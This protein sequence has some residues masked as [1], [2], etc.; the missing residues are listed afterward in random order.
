[1]TRL[2]S[3]RA[4]GQSTGAQGL[5]AP[6]RGCND[7]NPRHEIWSGTRRRQ[8]RGCGR[9]SP[10]CGRSLER[11]G[12][13]GDVRDTRRGG[14][15]RR[16]SSHEIATWPTVEAAKASLVGSYVVTGTDSDGK[17][18]VGTHILDV[19]MAPSG[20]LELDWDNGKQVGVGQVIG[21]V[22]AV[23]CLIKGRTVI[24]T[25]ND[26]PGWFALRQVVAPHR[27]GLARYRDVGEDVGQAVRSRLHPQV[28]RRFQGIE[29]NYLSP[30]M[31][32]TA[33]DIEAGHPANSRARPAQGRCG[34]SAGW[35]AADHD[36]AHDESADETDVAPQHQ[37]SSNPPQP[38]PEIRTQ[39]PACARR[40]PA[41]RRLIAFWL[42]CPFTRRER[43]L[44]AR[45]NANR[46]VR[47]VRANSFWASSRIPTDC[48]GR[49]PSTRYAGQT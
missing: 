39:D 10:A 22:L 11:M 43:S 47:C 18:Y 31:Q 23:A 3:G 9:R 30:P 8:K 42:P 16:S 15:S 14:R 7:E 40:W 46:C 34:R 19:S 28:V 41:R 35:S 4:C 25:M 48:C 27:P 32:L 5:E 36:R 37:L 13:L 21:N 44:S 29:L 12:R 24:L 49:R 6:P 20:A 26:R 38:L 17:P 33:F 2:A 45:S 1:M